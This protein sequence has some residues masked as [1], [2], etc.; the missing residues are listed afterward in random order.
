MPEL[1]G[2]RTSLNTLPLN[3]RLQK[4]L[5]NGL[6]W[7]NRLKNDVVQE[8]CHFFKKKYNIQS[9]SQSQSPLLAYKLFYITTL[10]IHYITTQIILF[11]NTCKFRRVRNSTKVHIGINLFT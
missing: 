8:K 9:P 7:L 11:Y 3:A 1:W 10:I 4:K 5:Y 6:R 2:I